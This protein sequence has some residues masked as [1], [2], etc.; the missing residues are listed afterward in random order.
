MS[1]GG[2]E[3]GLSEAIMGELLERMCPDE[4]TSGSLLLGDLVIVGVPGEMAAELGLKLKAQAKALTGAKHATIGGLA[5]EWISYIL[6]AD[7]YIKGGGYE[8][9]VSF[10][11]P[12]LGDR[13]MKEAVRGVRQLESSK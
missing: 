1:T 13:I 11:G 9:S 4:T 8:A 12:E 2:K 3:Y 5:N 10:Y 7:S 6:S